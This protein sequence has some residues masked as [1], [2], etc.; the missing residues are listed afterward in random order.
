MNILLDFIPFQHNGGVGGAASFAKAIYDELFR[1]KTDEHTL[2]AVCDKRVSKGQQYDYE[3]LAQKNDVQLLDLSDATLSSMIAKNKI[4]VFFIAIGQFYAGYDLSGIHC[5]TIMFIHDLYNLESSDN[6]VDLTIH[7]PNAESAW[8]RFKRITNV[9]IGRKKA[10]SLQSYERIMPLYAASN[11]V[12]YTVSDYSRMA[13]HY[14]FPEI[15]KPI[16]VCY[17]PDK[18]GRMDETIENAQ[19]NE[20]VKDGKKY[21]LMI[22]ANR[23]Y[24]NPHTLLRVFK[25]LAEEYPDLYVL[26]LKYGCSTH[27]RH[28]DIPF[29]SDSDLE[30]AYHHAYALVFASYFEGFGY[31]PIEAIKHGTPVVASNVTSIPEILGEAGVYFSPF[32]PADM[33]RALKMIIDNRDIR[34]AEIECQVE[35]VKQRQQDDLRH[36]VEQILTV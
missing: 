2:F 12:A 21:L 18:G 23:N 19:L 9:V 30:H 35:K 24:K 11:T 13:L 15:K 25:R 31:P 4:D 20:M 5:K 3:Q 1:K 8:L 17:S 14:Y 10:K 26:T 33:Y 22:A 29:L 6:L 16:H 28:I 7:D 36:L 34:K 32:Y 27:P